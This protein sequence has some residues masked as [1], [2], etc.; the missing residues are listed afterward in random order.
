[1]N[2]AR[3]RMERAKEAYAQ[4]VKDNEQLRSTVRF[5]EEAPARLES[6][7]QYY[8]GQWLDDRAEL[9][10][11]DYQSA[12]MDE[13]AIYLEVVEQYELMK[14]IILMAAIYINDERSY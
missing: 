6:L 13:D 8:F 10:K 1:M 5:L 9:E 7:A 3:E 12:V 4:V 14:Q 2:D 11:T